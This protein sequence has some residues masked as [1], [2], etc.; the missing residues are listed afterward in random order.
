M[1]HIPTVVFLTFP[2]WPDNSQFGSAVPLF[3]CFTTFTK[4]LDPIVTIVGIKDYRRACSNFLACRNFSWIKRRKCN[5]F[6]S[7]TG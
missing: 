4:I 5:I 3:S 6:R 1:Y 2:L 7:R